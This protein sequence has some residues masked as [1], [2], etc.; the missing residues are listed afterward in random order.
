[1]SHGKNIVNF[2]LELNHSHFKQDDFTTFLG[3]M[4]RL[5][6]F[7]LYNC[8]YLNSNGG[9]LLAIPFDIIQEITFLANYVLP[10]ENSILCT[11]SVLFV[12]K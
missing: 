11:V 10:F 4:K 12:Y 5:K 9:F 8:D 6:Y 7:T 3:E 2:K 1:M